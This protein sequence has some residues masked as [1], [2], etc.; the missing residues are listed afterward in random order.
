MLFF[1]LFFP[2]ILAT[3]Y[4]YS[5]CLAYSVEGLCR[6][7]IFSLSTASLWCLIDALKKKKV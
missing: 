1:I 7:S 2:N 4:Y 3:E 6:D 5:S